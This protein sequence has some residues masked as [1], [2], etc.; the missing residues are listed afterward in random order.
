M[1]WLETAQLLYQIQEQRKDLIKREAELKEQLIALSGDKTH[2]EGAYIFLK[3]IRKG[4]VQYKDIPELKSVDLEQYRS[5]L[6][7]SWSLKVIL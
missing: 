1:N 2:S 3:D 6:V 7:T 4:S 5:S